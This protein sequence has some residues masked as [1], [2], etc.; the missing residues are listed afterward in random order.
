M[1]EASI[2]VTLDIGG[3]AARA[4]AYDAVG[5]RSLASVAVPYPASSDVSDPGMFEPEG[6]WHAAVGALARLRHSLDEPSSRFLGI[7]VS[8]EPSRASSEGKESKRNGRS[9]GVRTVLHCRR[10]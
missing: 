3:S 9:F 2:V 4:V 6:W 7:T 5:Q 1:T 10:T 8:P